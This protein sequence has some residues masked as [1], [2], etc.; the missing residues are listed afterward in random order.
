MCEMQN[1]AAEE[2]CVR[3][4]MGEYLINTPW[5]IGTLSLQRVAQANPHTQNQL[6]LV[7]N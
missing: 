6:L 1:I 2:E 5:Q 3:L 4:Y 7:S